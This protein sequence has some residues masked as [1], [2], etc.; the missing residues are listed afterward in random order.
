MIGRGGCAVPEGQPWWNLYYRFAP[1]VLRRGYATEMAR[2][3]IEA[4]RAT[5]PA[6][7]VLAHLLE[8]NEASRRTAERVGLRLVWRGREA[9]D[10]DGSAMRLV[11]VDREPDAALLAAIERH[12]APPGAS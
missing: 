7:P 11:Y 8:H 10:P 6:R 2:A 3:A 12:C 5:D 9:S 1:S 4:A